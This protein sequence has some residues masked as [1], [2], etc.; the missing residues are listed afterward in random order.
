MC[1]FFIGDDMNNI[2]MKIAITQAT[3]AYKNG[4]VPVGCVIV[5]NNK[6]ISKI[7][8]LYFM[9]KFWQLKKHVINLRHGT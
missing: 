9:Q 8:M 2:Y 3:K 6:I 4:D 1:A 7:I 5:K